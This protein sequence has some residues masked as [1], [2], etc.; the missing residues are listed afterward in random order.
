MWCEE[1]LLQSGCY[2]TNSKSEETAEEDRK[3]NQNCHLYSSPVWPLGVSGRKNFCALTADTKRKLD[4]KAERV[5]GKD[6]RGPWVC[7]KR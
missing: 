6:L 4:R 1:G 2:K 7:N 5:T 3:D